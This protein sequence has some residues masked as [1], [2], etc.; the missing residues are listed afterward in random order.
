MSSRS[1]AQ[2]SVLKTEASK[3]FSMRVKLCLR[4]RLFANGLGFNAVGT[5]QHTSLLSERLNSWCSKRASQQSMHRSVQESCS[6]SF[7]AVF[8]LPSGVKLLPTA[9]TYHYL[10]GYDFLSPLPFLSL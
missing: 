7:E 6:S 5:S 1:V 9:M 3:S 4:G 10:W 2:G 8:L